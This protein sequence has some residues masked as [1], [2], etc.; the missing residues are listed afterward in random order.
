M[1]C[2]LVTGLLASVSIAAAA[3]ANIVINRNDLAPQAVES[4]TWREVTRLFAQIGVE[5]DANNAGRTIQVNFV[6]ATSPDFHPGALAFAT[7][8]NSGSPAITIFYN[9]VAKVAAYCSLPRGTVLAYVLAHELGHIL[10]Q[11]DSHSRAGVMKADWDLRDFYLM[12]D[13]RL[14]FQPSDGEMIRRETAVIQSPT[15]R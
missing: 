8:Y 12:T 15:I 13:G 6:E 10:L 3:D 9:R 2:F 1:N 4:P 5:L 14:A 7:P 11:S